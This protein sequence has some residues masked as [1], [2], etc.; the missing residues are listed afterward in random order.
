MEITVMTEMRLDKYLANAGAGTRTEVKCMIK[1]SMVAVNG[2][3]IKKPEYKVEAGK[4]Q[5]VCKGMAVP[6]EA[7]RYYMLHKPAGC[8][9]ATLD[10]RDETV[11]DLLDV[12]RKQ[13][14]FPVGRLD[15]DTEGLLLLTNDGVLTHHLLSPRH[16]VEKTYFV[17]VQGSVNQKEIDRFQEGVE[18]GDE[19]PTLPAKLVILDSGEIS[20]V[21]LTICEGRFHQVK[22]MFE[23]V[24]KKVLYLKRLSM[25][26]VCLDETLSKGA[27]RALTEEEIR[28][29]RG[30]SC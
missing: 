3:M 24:G 6:Y 10:N 1:K 28:K 13:E 5:V 14:L 11:L 23:A 4:D 26:T 9:S 22:R 2:Q 30:I 16:H 19:K 7:Y 18:I 29:L 21:E 17:R 8:V 27:Y 20:K 12:D 15:K 25:G